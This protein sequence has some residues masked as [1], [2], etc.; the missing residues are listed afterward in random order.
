MYRS[1]VVGL[2]GTN[3]SNATFA[4][5][6]RLCNGFDADLAG[7]GCKS[8]ECLCQPPA[9]AAIGA[10]RQV[11]AYLVPDTYSVRAWHSGCAGVVAAGVFAAGS[12][13]CLRLFN[14]VWIIFSLAS[15]AFSKRT[16]GMV[17]AKSRRR[18]QICIKRQYTGV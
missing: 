11:G 10:F 1:T 2:A 7:V 15:A 14:N 4:F 18:H 8:G 17:L 3:F 13:Q 6:C 12:G 9:G 5:V 16:S